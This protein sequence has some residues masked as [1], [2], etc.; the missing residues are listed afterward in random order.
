M[1]IIRSVR[2]VRLGSFS[3]LYLRS[4]SSDQRLICF[5]FSLQIVREFLNFGNE[6]VTQLKHQLEKQRAQLQQV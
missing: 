1:G 5:L 2:A 4:N 6:E 3:W